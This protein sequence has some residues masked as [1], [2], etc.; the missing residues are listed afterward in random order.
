VTMPNFLLVCTGISGTT[1]LYYYVKQHP[2]I[3]ET[4]KK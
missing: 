3:S 4:S 1:S 2:S